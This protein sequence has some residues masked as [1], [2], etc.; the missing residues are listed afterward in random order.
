MSTTPTHE[1]FTY[2]SPFEQPIFM[3]NTL[4]LYTHTRHVLLFPL[5]LLSN[6]DFNKATKTD[7]LLQFC[8]CS[9]HVSASISPPHRLSMSWY[10][11]QAQLLHRRPRGTGTGNAASSTISF[12]S[13]SA[14]GVATA[15]CSNCLETDSF[16]G[17]AHNL[18]IFAATC[19]TDLCLIMGEAGWV[20]GR[21]KQRWNNICKLSLFF[22]KVLFWEITTWVFILCIFHFHF[23]Y[24]DIFFCTAKRWPSVASLI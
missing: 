16:Q 4:H 20:Q 15:S 7:V 22:H 14:G 8:P 23:H 13:G 9:H 11:I 6:E 1:A 2:I 12:L 17:P 18:N 10:I 24:S 3:Y 19:L 21:I 5:K